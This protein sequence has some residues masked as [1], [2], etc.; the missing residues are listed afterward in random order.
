[1]ADTQPQVERTE[2]DPIFKQVLTDRCE[3]L[4]IPLRTQVEVGRM[5]RTMDALIRLSNPQEIEQVQTQTPFGYFREHNQVEF[6]GKG[7]P[8][9]IEGYHLILGRAHFYMGEQ[10]ISPSQM[11]V[12]IICSRKP[13]K[14]LYHCEDHVEFQKVDSAHYVSSEKLPVHIIP[15][16]ELAM[17]P[18]NYPLLVFAA[19]D[20]KL[21]EFLQKTLEE[22]NL[23]YI[24][25]AYA[26]RAEIT[27]E[28]LAMARRHYRLTRPEL[29]FIY[30]DIGQELLPFYNPGDLLKHLNT[31]DL[32][33]HLSTEVQRPLSEEERK[34]LRQLLEDQKKKSPT[35]L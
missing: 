24:R 29:E 33:K 18:Q 15:I 28:V 31:R 35:S 16:N 23:A 10:R 6:K 19:S 3:Q 5:P 30:N 20:R 8:L 14:V 32:L 2:I 21:R 12:T 4:N 27:K 22:R 7:D 9:T 13:R 34:M 25:Y 11:T 26:V 1:M 17:I